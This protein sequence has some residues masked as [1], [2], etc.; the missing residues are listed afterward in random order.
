ML[1]Y[2]VEFFSSMAMKYANGCATKALRAADVAREILLRLERVDAREL[3]CSGF[4]PRASTA[5]S[6]RKLA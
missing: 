1:T 5:A 4:S 3:A 2:C 6:S